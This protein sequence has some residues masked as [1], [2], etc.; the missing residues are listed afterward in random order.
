MVLSQC[1]R[2]GYE[3]RDEL[4][5]WPELFQLR[6]TVASSACRRKRI[7]GLTVMPAVAVRSPI[8][9]P[10][11]GL[12]QLASSD[13]LMTA[14]EVARL[15]AISEKTIYSYVSKGLI[16]YYKIQSSVR[17]RARDVNAWLSRQLYAS[18]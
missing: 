6:G 18:R 11:D 1:W 9:V 16:P 4:Q 17:F 8:A 14:K 5:L 13:R 3:I 15:L 2:I 12:D 10:S 7:R